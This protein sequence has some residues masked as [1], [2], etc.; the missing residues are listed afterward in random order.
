MFSHRWNRND[1][2]NKLVASPLRNQT[3]TP[4]L[5]AY[6]IIH[7]QLNSNHSSFHNIS[8]QI[9]TLSMLSILA[10]I[11]NYNVELEGVIIIY[12]RVRHTNRENR[13]VPPSIP[14]LCREHFITR[15]S[16]VYA[17]AIRPVSV[18]FVLCFLFYDRL[19]ISFWPGFLCFS[20]IFVFR[21][22]GI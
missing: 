18:S 5:Y 13:A 8:Q 10:Y 11:E 20:V 6:A 21:F 17:C 3:K 1:S 15:R 14:R 22:M 12:Q 16:T 4:L 2:A 9:G 7:R 19:S